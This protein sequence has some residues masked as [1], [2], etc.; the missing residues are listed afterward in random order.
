LGDWVIEGLHDASQPLST[1]VRQALLW[2]IPFPLLQGIAQLYLGFLVRV[3][4][5][6]V[7][8]YATLASIGASV[9]AVFGLLPTS[10]VQT[11]PISLPILVTYVGLLVELG[12]ILWGNHLHTRP[13]LRRQDRAISFAYV[14]RF[15]WP[16][17]LIMAIQGLSRPLIN[18]F[19]AREPNGTE[20]LATL[21]IALSLGH[22][23]YGWVNEIRNLAPAYRDQPDHLRQIPRFALGCGLLS[24]G[25][26]VILFWTPLRDYIVGTLIGV[27]ES[28]VQQA[29]A[30]LRLFTFFPL[31]VMVRGYLHGVGLVKHRTQVMAPSAPA[32]I[33][34]V[35]VMLNV[36]PLVGVH[37]AARGVASLLSGFVTE[38]LVVLWGLRGQWR[39]LAAQPLAPEDP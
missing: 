37:G 13:L 30:P 25:I 4:R 12:V 38:A 34:A 39:D 28:L 22:L 16:L 8:I 3:H 5:T 29:A 31:A 2:L 27:D 21:T 1:L 32:R 19:M 15:F 17:A 11:N 10:L 24:F 20:V 35:L 33:V 6:D 36:L 18:L 7:V 26:M 9:A 23:P 14:I